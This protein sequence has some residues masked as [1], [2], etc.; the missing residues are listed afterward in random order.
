MIKT[1]VS[2]I[3]FFLRTWEN[4]VFW[5]KVQT[6]RFV[7]FTNSFLSKA[8]TRLIS[9]IFL[10]EITK[11]QDKGS[12]TENNEMQSIS[13]KLPFNIQTKINGQFS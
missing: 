6:S 1:H 2:Q 11:I 4:E 7:V 3:V 12:R 10:I 9:S 13:E 8:I 5:R